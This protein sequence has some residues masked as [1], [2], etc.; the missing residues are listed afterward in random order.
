M[1]SFPNV[2]NA[3]A[4]SS[5][6]ALAYG[7]LFAP[8]IPLAYSAPY[9]KVRAY[10]HRADLLAIGLH[11]LVHTLGFSLHAEVEAYLMASTIEDG[12]VQEGDA[13]CED[14]IPCFDGTGV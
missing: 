3:E 7:S 12:F 1:F 14:F 11:H 10:V 9:G 2:P 13:A 5:V 8:H 4:L 6:P